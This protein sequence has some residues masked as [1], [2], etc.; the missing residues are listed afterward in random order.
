M[1][2]R[3]PVPAGILLALLLL[4]STAAPVMGEC[5]PDHHATDPGGVAMTMAADSNDAGTQAP[6]SPTDCG[7]PSHHGQSHP[8]GGCGLA[9]GCSATTFAG[10]EMVGV[11]AAAVVRSDAPV[12]DLQVHLRSI[13]PTSP[14][15]KP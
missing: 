13:R 5:A 12:L 8:P 7:H 15:P 9:F 14:P 4:Q 10:A 6:L 2:R 1:T 3:H 11:C